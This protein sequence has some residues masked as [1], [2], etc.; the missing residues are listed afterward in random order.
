M[1]WLQAEHP[2]TS[3]ILSSDS[4]NRC[5]SSS[6][7]AVGVYLERLSVTPSDL[8]AAP[9]SA[10]PT[11]NGGGG[12]GGGANGGAGGGAGGGS[13]C[14]SSPKSGCRSPRGSSFGLGGA[15]SPKKTPRSSAGGAPERSGLRK[16]I[17]LDG[18]SAYTKEST[19]DWVVESSQ[20]GEYD[21]GG[22]YRDRQSLRLVPPGR[23]RTPSSATPAAA[24]DDGPAG[25]SEERAGQ[26]DPVGACRTA[27]VFILQPLG[28]RGTLVIHQGITTV[29]AST[30]DAARP[31]AFGGAA[32]T[33]GVAA[34]RRSSAA[35]FG[36]RRLVGS[37]A[38][39][40]P[41]ALAAVSLDV[42]AVAVQVDVRQYAVLNEAV[43]ALAMS[44]RRFRF[45]IVRP[46][47]AVLDD[48]EAWWR[49]AIRYYIFSFFFR[50]ITGT[51][52]G[53]QR[54]RG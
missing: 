3:P 17:E 49:Y 52:K 38:T 30:V 47:S 12:G 23:G 11:R 53:T 20:T 8:A 1:V 22:R 15:S 41:P 54:G 43:S 10:S 34:G 40:A 27:P 9:A 2:H 28:V 24:A 31:G 33:G 13:S 32:D 7:S 45:R 5:P 44:Q 51:V 19:A 29:Q 48:P 26:T 39:N 21:S 14:A 42:D 37:G 16:D 46:T 35:G 18:L 4:P 50:Y 36:G 6:S 25:D